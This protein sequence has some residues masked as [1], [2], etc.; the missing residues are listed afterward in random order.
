MEGF[1]PVNKLTTEHI[2]VP[3]EAFKIGDEIPAVVTEIDHNNRKLY[4]STT[5][6]FKSR[7]DAEMQAYLSAHKPATNTLGEA[8]LDDAINN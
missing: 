1:V 7:E 8:G 5:D 2:K 4:L 6:F 3:S